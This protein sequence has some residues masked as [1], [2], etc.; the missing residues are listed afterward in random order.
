VATGSSTAAEHATWEA[1]QRQ[2]GHRWPRCWTLPE[3]C[4]LMCTNPRVYTAWKAIRGARRWARSA[5]GTRSILR[6]VRHD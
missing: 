6:E 5:L 1:W 3:Y 4:A 2:G